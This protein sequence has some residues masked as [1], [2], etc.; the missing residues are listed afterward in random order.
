VSRVATILRSTRGLSLLELTVVLGILA[1]AGSIA[2]SWVDPGPRHLE[3]AAEAVAANV[4]VAR[5]FAISRGA[6]YEVRVFDATNLRI[7][8]LRLQ[9]EAD[10]TSP[11]VL[12]GVEF[13]FLPLPP[14]VR[15]VTTPGQVIEFDSAGAMVGGTAPV[16]VVIEESVHGLTRTVTIWPSGQ[17]VSG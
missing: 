15:F 4:R 13:R 17:V 6:H 14:N 10:P 8:R 16:A 2:I 5:A 1:V 9:D 11:W 3:N 12:D 7:A